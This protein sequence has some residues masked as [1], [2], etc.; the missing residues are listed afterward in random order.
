MKKII[1]V[2]LLFLAVFINNNASAAVF[3]V[4]IAQD[5]DVISGTQWIN[6]NKS[7][8]GINSEIE[9][10]RANDGY[11]TKHIAYLGF[12]LF[13]NNYLREALFRGDRIDSYKLYAYNVRN[14]AM[15]DAVIEDV[16]T[17]IYY[18]NNDDWD[19]GQHQNWAVINSSNPLDGMTYDNQVGYSE[20]LATENEQDTNKWYSWEFSANAFLLDEINDNPNYLSLAMV[21]NELNK[22]SSWW[23]VS[24]FVSKENQSNPHPYIEVHTSPVPEPATMLLLGPA[25]LVLIGYKRKY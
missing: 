16:I 10:I 22:S 5:T 3:F 18:V 7:N 14:F 13:S 4:D 9:P 20:Y 19:Q 1:I 11:N 23:L 12:D 8:Q 2:G 6:E 17:S 24:S 25:L 21:P 15:G